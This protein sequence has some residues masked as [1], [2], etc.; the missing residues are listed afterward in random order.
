MIECKSGISYGPSDIKAFGRLATSLEKI[1]CIVCL[2][3]TPYP[4]TKEV[5]AIPLKTIGY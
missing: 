5:Y 3:D 2:T 4:V 1:G